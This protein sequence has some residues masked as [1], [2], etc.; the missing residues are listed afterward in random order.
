[1]S[2]LKIVSNPKLTERADRLWPYL[3]E[4]ICFIGMAV[5]LFYINAPAWLSLFLLGGA[6]ALIVLAIV[7]SK[8]K[9]SGHATGMGGL[10]AM[11]FYLM[12]SGNSLGSLQWEFLTI[13][14]LSGAVCTSRI[15]LERHT[16]G[17]VAAGF[18]NGAVWVL[19]LPLIYQAL[20]QL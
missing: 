7:N 15:I 18:L 8:W 17:Q 10:S 4:T 13:I 6:V 5:Y 3:L 16:L 11:I 14:I 20:T 19:A 1:M 12:L 9:M 2:K